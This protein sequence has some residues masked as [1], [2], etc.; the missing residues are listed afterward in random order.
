MSIWQISP[1]VRVWD[2]GMLYVSFNNIFRN[3]TVIN[4]DEFVNGSKFSQT[5]SAFFDCKIAGT[6][7]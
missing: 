6:L 4:L 5:M 7:W 3:Y 2:I 1:D